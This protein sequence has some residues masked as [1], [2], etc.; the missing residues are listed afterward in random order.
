MKL[1]Y[2]RL[3]EYC[4]GRPIRLV[5][6]RDV[7]NQSRLQQDFQAVKTICGVF[8]CCVP[9]TRNAGAFGV[10]RSRSSHMLPE[11]CVD[12]TDGHSLDVVTRLYGTGVTARN[13]GSSS[14]LA[15][16]VSHVSA[17]VPPSAEL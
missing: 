12:T 16:S 7:V 4:I 15:P 6:R 17:D 11:V 1:S 2:S 9:T 10:F 8:P 14:N 13:M 5:I 3:P